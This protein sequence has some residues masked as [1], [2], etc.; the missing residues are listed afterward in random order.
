M[1]L[2]HIEMNKHGVARVTL[3]RPEVHNALNEALIHE[4]TECIHMLGRHTN[5]RVIVLT[6]AGRSFSA[7]ADLN[8][9]QRAANQSEDENRA[10]A[11]RLA[12]LFETLNTC[13]RPIVGLIN[14]AALGGGVGLTACCDIAVAHTRAQFG[15]TEVRIGLIPATISPYVTAKIGQAQA[16]RYMLT[17]ERFGAEVAQKIG[18]VHEVSDDIDAAAQSII[19]ALIT[20]GPEAMAATKTLIADVASRPITQ[21]LMDMTAHR[22]AARRAS[23]EGREGIAAFLEKRAPGWTE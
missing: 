19:D 1:S 9:M 10:D 16:R 12:K 14:G 7:G 5:V 17:A 8:W 22:I 4:L 20:N 6:G 15:L 2:V 11:L 21:D 3:N 23:A 18:L 13:P